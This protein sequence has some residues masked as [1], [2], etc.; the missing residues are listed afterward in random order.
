MVLSVNWFVKI[1]YGV[2]STFRK[3]TACHGSMSIR[4]FSHNIFVD[5]DRKIPQN[6][7]CTNAHWLESFQSVSTILQS[8]HEWSTYHEWMSSMRVLLLHYKLGIWLDYRHLPNTN[9]QVNVPDTSRIVET[10]VKHSQKSIS[11]SSME[12]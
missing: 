5:L 8:L 11:I 4:L 7:D 1:L 6:V 2:T 10:F 9:Y 3:S 12:W